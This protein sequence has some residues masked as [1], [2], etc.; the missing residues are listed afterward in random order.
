MVRLESLSKSLNDL[1]R[2]DILIHWCHF[3]VTAN[4]LLALKEFPIKLHKT[5]QFNIVY[6]QIHMGH[7]K[8]VGKCNLRMTNVLIL[9]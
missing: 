6:G 3:T 9:N 1:T 7:N 8:S 2:L 5:R 4:Y